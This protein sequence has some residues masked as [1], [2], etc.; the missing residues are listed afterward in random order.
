ME[1]FDASIV[2]IFIAVLIIK[3]FQ[4]LIMNRLIYYFTKQ[5]HRTNEYIST[6]AYK[7]AYCIDLESAFETFFFRETMH[8]CFYILLFPSGSP[9]Y[10]GFFESFH[11][12]CF[13]LFSFVFV[14]FFIP[15]RTY[16]FSFNSISFVFICFQSISFISFYPFFFFCDF[17]E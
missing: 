2:F 14:V 17:Q 11:F 4:L 16:L 15:V 13:R 3:T 10:L 5:T 7:C 9:F 1:K 12:I 8:S 6:S